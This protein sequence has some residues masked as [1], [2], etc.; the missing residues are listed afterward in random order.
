MNDW[1]A[2]DVQKWEYVPLGPFLAKNFA[3]TIS[4]WVVM[5]DALEPFITDAIEQD[6]KPLPYLDDSSSRRTFDIN[7]QAA[8]RSEKMSESV[9]VST[10]YVKNRNHSSHMKEIFHSKWTVKKVYLI[11]R[12]NGFCPS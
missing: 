11:K 8:I 12:N 9:T 4:P 10:T 5:L 3:T 6:P 2:R 1:S 7:L